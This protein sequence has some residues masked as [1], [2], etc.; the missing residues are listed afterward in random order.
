MKTSFRT[1]CGGE[2]GTRYKRTTWAKNGKKRIVW[3]CVSRLDYGK[4]Y[5]HNSPTIDETVL[6][7]AIL[8]AIN[9]LQSERK[10]L[11]HRI[12][13]SMENE[14]LP[15]LDSKM[16][17]GDINTRLAELEYD[18]QKM[19]ARAA[20]DGDYEAYTEKFRAIAEEIAG[21]KEKRSII[22][23]HRAGSKT[24]LRI[25]YAVDFFENSSSDLTKWD[26]SLIRQVI[27]WVKILSAEEILVCLR[28]GIEIRQR[29][30]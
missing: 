21:L 4:K 23:A 20:D 25:R 12:A 24:D 19:L 14:L 18:F 30:G 13:G 17:L 29:M 6:Q 11:I 15:E 5:C 9:S 8:A 26:E 7:G 2:C 1:N 10:L 16:S 28:G 22:E 27:D 3:R